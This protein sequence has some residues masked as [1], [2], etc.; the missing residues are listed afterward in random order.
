MV[1]FTQVDWLGQTSSCVR[2]GG[3]EGPRMVIDET[4]KG[5]GIACWGRAENLGFGLSLCP[6]IWE[7][8]EST[9]AARRVCVG[10]EAES[11][12]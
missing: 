11:Q 6:G 12:Q 10:G 7:F 8:Q 3:D 2:D 1:S 4:V 9:P 5:C